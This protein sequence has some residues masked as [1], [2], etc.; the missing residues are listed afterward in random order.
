MMIG[1]RRGDGLLSIASGSIFVAFTVFAFAGSAGSLAQGSAGVSARDILGNT[2]VKGGLIVHLGCW[3]GRLTAALR[4]SN[5]YLVHGLDRDAENV[6][7]A[8]EHVRSLGLYGPV[9]VEQCDGKSLPYADNLVNLV[10]S[11]RRPLIPIDEIMRVLCPNGVAY[12]KQDGTWTK[13]TKP[14]PDDIGEWNH[15][16]NGADNNAVAADRR[17]GPPRRLQWKSDPVWCRSHNGVSSSILLVLS[18]GGR[19]FSII[20][21]GLTGQPGVADLWTLVAR[22]AFNGTLLWKKHSTGLCFGRSD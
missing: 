9:S 12:I 5:S 20:D 21:E 1:A 4:P 2:D 11:E 3:D 13:K 10:V 7:W 19:L 17:V 8:R 16:L 15:Y 22:D 14:V 6:A 18:S